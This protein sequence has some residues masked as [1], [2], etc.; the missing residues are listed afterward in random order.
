M[1]KKAGEGLLS[2][3]VVAQCLG[4]QQRAVTHFFK[5]TDNG[6]Q[7]WPGCLIQEAQKLSLVV[8]IPHAIAAV[9]EQKA[10][11]WLSGNRMLKYQALL[12]ENDVTLKQ[13]SLL[14]LPC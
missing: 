9:L 7:G 12:E 6:A 5:Q 11:H 4:N 13:L 3:G 10:G 14:T 8:Y 1:R 2:S